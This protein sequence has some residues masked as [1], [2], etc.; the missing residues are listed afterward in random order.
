MTREEL[1]KLMKG[2]RDR[3]IWH[4]TTESGKEL[5]G[6]DIEDAVIEQ[7]EQEPCEDA[8]SRQAAI[9]AME[10]CD[11]TKSV[12]DGLALYKESVVEAL[13]GLPSASGTEKS[14]KI[15]HWIK[16][17]AV[18]IVGY[19]DTENYIKLPAQEC[20]ICHKPHIKGYGADFCPNCGAKMSEGGE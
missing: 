3:G 16:S 14:N 13:K 6:K 17:D 11:F 15:G 10:Y 5:S 2:M 18:L 1:L 7:L 20:S 19:A 8:I 12:N 9:E 4:F